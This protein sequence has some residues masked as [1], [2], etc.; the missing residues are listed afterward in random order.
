M[1][2]E[3]IVF[4]DVDVA[5]EVEIEVAIQAVD[6]L[7]VD[8]VV[9]VEL[10]VLVLV[11]VLLLDVVHPPRIGQTLR[12]PYLFHSASSYTARTFLSSLTV[13]QIVA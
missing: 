11:V 2:W 5:L 1:L 3:T 4:Q 13:S 8:E 6:L 12:F 10:V 7:L 9:V